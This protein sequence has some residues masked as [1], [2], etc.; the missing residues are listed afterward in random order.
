[1]KL[2]VIGGTGLIGSQVVQ[3]L[4][5]AGHEA[6][7]HSLSTGVDVLTGQG[8]DTA[9]AGTDVVV[10]LTNSSTFD[11]ASS[12]FFQPR[13]TTSW[14]ARNPGTAARGLSTG[15]IA[16]DRGAAR[17]LRQEISSR[18]C[19]HSLASTEYSRLSRH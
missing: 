8:V 11:D 19:D 2:A 10:N 4:N 12:A 14:S 6:V 5:A 1:M 17:S 18:C 15:R 13:W 7:P 16:N 9:L 3:N